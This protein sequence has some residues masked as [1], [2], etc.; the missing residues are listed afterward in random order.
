MARQ[1]CDY[2]EDEHLHELWKYSQNTIAVSTNSRKEIG[3]FNL[4]KGL[5]LLQVKWYFYGSSPV[6]PSGSWYRIGDTPSPS[7]IYNNVLEYKCM[8]NNEALQSVIVF[9]TTGATEHLEAYCNGTGGTFNIARCEVYGV[10][11]R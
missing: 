8:D 1:E 7:G 2:F 11:I 3:T 6:W 4:P 5:W 10:K 9:E